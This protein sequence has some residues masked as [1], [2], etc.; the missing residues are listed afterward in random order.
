MR[1]Y[2]F[3]SY[4]TI[5]ETE[6]KEKLK[7]ENKTDTDIVITLE[8]AD[9]DGETIPLIT[10]GVPLVIRPCNSGQTGFIFSMVNLSISS[11]S[12]AEQATFRV[13]ARN[14]ESY[15]VVYESELVT[16]NLH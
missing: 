10:T 1:N 3:I 11:L 16:I 4:S 15:T 14:S 7:V 5:T 6:R 2:V 8:D 9:V 12:E 13:I